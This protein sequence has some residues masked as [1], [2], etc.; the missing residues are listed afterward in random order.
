MLR[1][2]L[3]WAR[4]T[5]PAIGGEQ[6]AS[7]QTEYLGKTSDSAMLFPY[8]MYAN[9]PS[10]ALALIASVQDHPDNRVALGC[11]LKD[12]PQLEGGEVAL[13]HPS[14]GSIIKWN[15]DG[16]LLVSNGAATLTMEG[17]TLTLTGNLVV[18]G[19]MTNNGKDVGDTHQHAQAADSAG[20]T[21][22]NIVGVL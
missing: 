10:N 19:T 17:N 8:G 5:K 15:V 3:R 4:I 11:L 6:F 16:N 2:L 14:T 22:A 18:D 21:E 20:N 9:A 13:Y 1:N 7:Q 12:R